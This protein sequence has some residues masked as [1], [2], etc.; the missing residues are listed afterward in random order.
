MRPGVLAIFLLALPA[1]AGCAQG[2]Q[3]GSAGPRPEPPG[4]R[5]VLAGEPFADARHCVGYSLR[6]A[7]APTDL[8]PLVPA[9][10]S[11]ANPVAPTVRVLATRC[12][13]QTVAFVGVAMRAGGATAPEAEYLLHVFHEG[14]DNER[15][16]DDWARLGLPVVPA[17]VTVGN[18]VDYLG[19]ETAQGWAVRAWFASDR[20]PGQQYEQAA[21]YGAG[22]PVVLSWAEESAVLTTPMTV[23]SV[24]FGPATSLEGARVLPVTDGTWWGAYNAWYRE[25]WP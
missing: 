24:A 5:P 8:Q 17:T 23:T 21:R 14:R 16:P 11:F 22:E 6:T 18:R 13:D 20:N 12:P 9:T 2:P 10:W 25:G 15:V 4:S 1:L 3:D 7:V 19:I